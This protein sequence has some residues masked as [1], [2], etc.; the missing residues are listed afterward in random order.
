M[1]IKVDKVEGGFRADFVELP[2]MP[3]VGDGKTEGDAV[4]TLFIRNYK[5][6]QNLLNFNYLEINGVPYESLYKRT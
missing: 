5:N 6:L 2:G 1:K 4:A 3:Y